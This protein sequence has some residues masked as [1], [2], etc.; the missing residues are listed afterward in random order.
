M[1]DAPMETDEP[2]EAWGASSSPVKAPPSNSF[3]AQK[4]QN[5]SFAPRNK[6]YQSQPATSSL[7]KPASEWDAP[8]T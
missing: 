8:M 1:W 7:S 5:N 2:Q 4:P 6:P 3:D